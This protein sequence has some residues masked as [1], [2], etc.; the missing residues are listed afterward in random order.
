[1]AISVV[2]DRAKTETDFRREVIWL[3]ERWVGMEHLF[4]WSEAGQFVADGLVIAQV[5]GRPVRLSYL[6]RCDSAWRV[7]AVKVE[8]LP[9]GPKLHLLSDG[10]GAWCD[11]LG[12]ELPA[13][14]GAID[15]DISLTPFTNT[16]PIRRLRLDPGESRA[17]RVACVDAPSL[18][19][20]VAEHRYTC[21]ASDADG[22]RYLFESG[23][24]RAD[25]AVDQDGLVLDYADGW[26][27]SGEP[28]R[29]S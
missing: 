8:V 20:S 27:Q 9:R 28:P 3:A 23:T 6:I 18:S 16:L 24:F 22:G 12:S 1:V 2:A 21:L 5:D 4:T 26:R 7:R 25:L 14:N 11:E 17:L 10:V 15:V 19:L 13:L 29:G